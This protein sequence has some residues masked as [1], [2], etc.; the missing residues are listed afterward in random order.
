MEKGIKKISYKVLTLVL[1]ICIVSGAAAPAY[2]APTTID[3]W[4]QYDGSGWS[5][6]SSS[7]TFSWNTNMANSSEFVILSYLRDLYSS[8]KHYFI[9]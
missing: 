1:C 6:N 2:A 3:Q 8:V 4:A 5:Y 9:K 7:G